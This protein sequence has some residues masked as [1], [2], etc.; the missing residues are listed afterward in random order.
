MS[1]A[2]LLVIA[3][4]NFLGFPACFAASA[5]IPCYLADCKQCVFFTDVLTLPTETLNLSTSLVQIAGSVKRVIQQG[6]LT[7]YSK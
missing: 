2:Y 4:L 6:L 3:S 1:S 7:G 5:H